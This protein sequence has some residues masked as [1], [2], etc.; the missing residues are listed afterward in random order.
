MKRILLLLM[1]GGALASGAVRAADF[2]DPK[3]LVEALYQPY[4]QGR[5]PIDLA[6]F[7]TDG[8]KAMFARH[9]QMEAS[10]GGIGEPL[11]VADVRQPEFDPFVDARNYLLFDLNIS[12][13]VVNGDHALVNVSYKNFAHPT[14]LSVSLLKTP[15]GWKVDDIAS[16]GAD[17]HWLLSWLLTY[18]PLGTD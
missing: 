9:R 16:M 3:A 13:A 8:L 4:T 14:E 10:T 1:V 15:E 17:Q 18:D 12:D 11:K 6:S 2:E 7:Y 5:Q